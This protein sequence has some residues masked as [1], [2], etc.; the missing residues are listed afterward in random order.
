MSIYLSIYL[1]ALYIYICVC[2]F[3]FIFKF[4]RAGG[5]DPRLCSKRG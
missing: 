1:S 3:I 4:V 5:S 2:V